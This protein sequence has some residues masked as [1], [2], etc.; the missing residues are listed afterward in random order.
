MIGTSIAQACILGCPASRA[1]NGGL[2]QPFITSE[3]T[4]SP[5]ANHT[6]SNL[7]RTFLFFL[8]FCSGSHH[9]QLVKYGSN[10]TYIRKL[11]TYIRTLGFEEKSKE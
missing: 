10:H 4:H 11:L 6:S 5:N 9:S 7:G 2:K 3:R 8:F 1:G